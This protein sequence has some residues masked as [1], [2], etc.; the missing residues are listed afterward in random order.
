[1][2]TPLLLLIVL[3]VAVTGC[4]KHDGES[5]SPQSPTITYI[6]TLGDITYLG[7]KLSTIGHY[8]LL[9]GDNQRLI[10][11]RREDSVSTPS[12]NPADPD[13]LIAKTLV[14]YSFIWKDGKIAASNLDS[15]VSV[16]TRGGKVMSEDC[17]TDS[18]YGVYFYSGN[19]LDSI[20]FITY[21]NQDHPKKTIFEYGPDGNISKETNTFFPQVS[22]PSL[23]ALKP[24]K[25]IAAF[26][27][28][29]H[30]NPWNLLVKQV[31]VILPTV[32]EAHNI[33]KN[34]MIETDVEV[35]F[36]GDT[37]NIR[38]SKTYTYNSAGYP[39]QEV[40][41]GLK[42]DTIFYQYQ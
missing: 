11:L 40:M 36:P 1:M 23:P 13:P 8:H 28:D 20:L 2:R 26:K 35:I 21:T 10:G 5:P 31:G 17:L 42:P 41:P 37:A 22:Y 34:N 3:I 19:R 24:A 30:L 12:V 6:S 32:L 27:Y 4:Q 38:L 33:S 14:R 29:R 39:M 25:T 7:A 18:P 16:E 9:Y 15:M